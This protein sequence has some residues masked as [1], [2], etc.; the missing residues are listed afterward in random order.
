MTFDLLDIKFH[1]TEAAN[2]TKLGNA[3]IKNKKKQVL[4]GSKNIS[5][6][7][8]FFCDNLVMKAKYKSV[9]L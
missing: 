3:G 5:K 9:F 6:G 7:E 1:H 2:A 4:F 8:V